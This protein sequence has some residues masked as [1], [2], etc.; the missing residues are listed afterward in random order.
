MKITK[1]DRAL[2][3]RIVEQEFGQVC[4]SKRT[5]ARQA[6]S[7]S[8]ANRSKKLTASAGRNRIRGRRRDDIPETCPDA[9]P[10]P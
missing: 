2:L 3:S 9:F 7:K 10:F 1:E 5:A 4:L 6:R 8:V